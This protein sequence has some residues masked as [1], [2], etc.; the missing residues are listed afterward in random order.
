MIGGDRQ[1]DRQPGYNTSSSEAVKINNFF[2]IK[3]S[4][5]AI[6]NVSSIVAAAF[7]Q[8]LNSQSNSKTLHPLSGQEN[9]FFVK[10]TVTCVRVTW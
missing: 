9:N 5:Q 6:N 4:N 8:Y 7:K 3:Q 1:I 10:I 2:K